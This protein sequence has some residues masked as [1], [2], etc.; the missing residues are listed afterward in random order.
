MCEIIVLGIVACGAVAETAWTLLR[1]AMRADA[2]D[3]WLG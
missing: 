1:V 3:E 2:A